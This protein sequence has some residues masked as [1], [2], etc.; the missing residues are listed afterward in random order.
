VALLVFALRPPRRKRNVTG[1]PE[2]PKV[3][4][5]RTY[6]WWSLACLALPAVIY[7]ASAMSANLNLGLRHILPVY[8]FIFIALGLGLTRLM[9]RSI[10][11]GAVL[12]VAIVLGLAGESFAAY[13]DYLAFFNAP[14][15]GSRGGINLL[16]DSNLDWGQDLKLLA[17]W[18]RDHMDKPLYLSYFGVADPK[19]YRVNAIHVPPVAGGWLFTV[20]WSEFT[21]LPQ[22]PCYFAV[23]ATNLQCIYI[24]RPE[25]IQ[26]YEKLRVEEPVAVLGGSIY[27]YE[28]RPSAP[29]MPRQP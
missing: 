17:S 6:D 14:S 11:F 15:G 12:A 1:E 4:A 9:K 24:V 23:S 13:P 26:A 28:F 2:P 10:Q 5:W 7:A 25:F 22:P 3:S 8:P 19:F 20:F 27:I 18:Q 29:Q 16:G 21:S